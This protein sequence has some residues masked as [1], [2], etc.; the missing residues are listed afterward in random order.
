MP[1]ADI[2]NVEN[3]RRAACHALAAD[4]PAPPLKGDPH[5]SLNWTYLNDKFPGF[6]QSEVWGEEGGVD[7]RYILLAT[8][9]QV[10]FL[11]GCKRV[12]MDGTYKLVEQ[13][14][15][16]LLSLNGFLKNRKGKRLTNLT[17]Y[18]PLI[19]L[20]LL[21]E[22][23]QVPLGFAL[24]LRQKSADYV[25]VLKGLKDI[26]TMP[27]I[28]EIMDFE[29]AVWK[30]VKTVFPEVQHF[31]CLFHWKQAVM[32][33]VCLEFQLLEF[34]LLAIYILQVCDMGLKTQYQHRDS[35]YLTIN[36]ILALPYLPHNLIEEQFQTIRSQSD[37][38]LTR[39]INYVVDLD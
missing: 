32:K 23:K 1:G 29:A 20:L 2:P 38:S 9:T 27:V 36:E 31:G 17:Y 22:T 33:K 12:Y 24:M 7:V 34:Q 37:E 11:S 6:F 25:A 28:K 13:P 5:F 16:Q 21:G 18:I 19:H 4:R 14:F 30:A 8:S 15:R 3:L 39:L 26:A 10:K 35:T